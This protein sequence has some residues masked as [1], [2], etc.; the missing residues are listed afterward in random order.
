M[1]DVNSASQEIAASMQDISASSQEINASSQEV[2][3]TIDELAKRSEEG[4]QKALEIEKRAGEILDSVKNSREEAKKLYSEKQVNIL[5]SIEDAKVVDD[6]EKMAEIISQIAGQTNLLA[7]NAA[8]EAARAGEQ[9]KGFS[10]VAEEVRKLAE[11]S[12]QTVS[13]IESVVGQVR[14]AFSNMCINSEDILKFI[15]ENV[16][17]NYDIFE[18]AVIQYDEDGK[19]ISCL[20]E[21]LAAS[22]E[23]VA[24]SVEQTVKAIESV[25]SSSSEAAAGSEEISAKISQVTEAVDDIANVSQKQSELADKLNNIVQK[26]KV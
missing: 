20:V 14:T 10:V 2:E 4:S 1:Q 13:R 15:N 11:Q 5:K 22:A 23:E 25:S 7:L 18:N 24:A 6:I 8:I 21:N 3:K 16:R 17:S 9:G 19:F 12:S 26:F